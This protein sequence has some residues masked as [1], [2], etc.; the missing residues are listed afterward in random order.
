MQLSEKSLETQTHKNIQ[1]VD[2][3]QK[4]S[5]VAI[6]RSIEEFIERKREEALQGDIADLD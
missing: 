4:K 1:P 6:R 2:K 3:S 5:G